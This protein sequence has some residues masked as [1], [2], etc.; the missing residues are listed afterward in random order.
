MAAGH[1]NSEPQKIRPPPSASFLLS[2]RGL[3]HTAH[4]TR[5]TLRLLLRFGSFLS[6]SVFFFSSGLPSFSASRLPLRSAPF[7][8]RAPRH[9]LRIPSGFFSG[10]RI[11]PQLRPAFKAEKVLIFVF[12]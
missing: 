8:S 4:G 10:G 11:S 6:F 12:H 3:A 5:L 7:A 2:L 1:R 9:R